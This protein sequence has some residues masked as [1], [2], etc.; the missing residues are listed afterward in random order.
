MKNITLLLL[1]CLAASLL[2][3]QQEGTI[4][5]SEKMK[6]EIKLPE[7][8]PIPIEELR[9]MMPSERISQKVLHFNDKASLYMAAE[10]GK[11][12]DHEI[13]TGT[14]EVQIKIR[15]VGENAENKIF[16][17]LKTKATTQKR[18]FMGKMFLIEDEQNK[19]AW[20]LGT[21]SKKILDYNCRKATSQSDERTIV[22]W[23]STEIPISSGPDLYAGLP[24]MILEIESTSDNGSRTITATNIDFNPLA[25]DLIQAPKKGKKISRK[26]FAKV[27]E[28]KTKEMEEQMGGQGGI[29]FIRN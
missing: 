11:E 23:F 3:A 17:N 28:E 10:Q 4:T 21:E 8:S 14:D 13:N 27:V 12:E 9:K 22:A 24:G 1:I 18:D 20:K 15:M 29:R 2:P 19:L 26:A 7:N 5:F 16:Q 25:P 6:I